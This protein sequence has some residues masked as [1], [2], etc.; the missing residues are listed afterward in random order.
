MLGLQKGLFVEQSA[1]VTHP[2]MQLRTIPQTGFALG[3]FA[4]TR[5]SVQ[6]PLGPQIG[7]A[8]G[9]F[10][11]T[12]QA[13]HDPAAQNCVGALQSESVRHCAQA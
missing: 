5:H 2:A 7:V 9:Q 4:S 3:Q 11:S 10:A 8:L 13:T 6:A 1:L 12:V